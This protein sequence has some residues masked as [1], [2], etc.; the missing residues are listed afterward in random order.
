MAVS[1]SLVST[2][3][4]SHHTNDCFHLRQEVRG[5]ALGGTESGGVAERKGCFELG[6]SDRGGLSLHDGERGTGPETFCP[7]CWD[8]GDVGDVEEEVDL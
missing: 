5:T 1:S 6:G 4:I 7:L 8:V 2:A 3:N